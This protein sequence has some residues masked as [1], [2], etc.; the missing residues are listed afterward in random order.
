MD[1]DRAYI[2]SG[3]HHRRPQASQQ[4]ASLGFSESQR[5]WLDPADY[6]GPPLFPCQTWRDPYWN[7]LLTQGEMECFRGHWM[8]WK[9]LVDSGKPCAVVF[10][11]DLKAIDGL[12]DLTVAVRDFTYLG[13]KFLEEPTSEADG[14]LKPGYTYWTIGYSLTREIAQ[15]LLDSVAPDAI[16]PLDEFLPYHYGSNPNVD[17]LKHRQKAP[18][19]IQAFSLPQWIVEPS[20]EEESRTENSPSAFDLQGILFATDKEK[21]SEALSAYQAVEG[22][23]LEV[24][25]EGEPSWDTSGRGGI[26]KLQWLKKHLEGMPPEDKKKRIVLAVDGYDTLPAVFSGRNLTQRFAE[27]GARIV[28]G[29][30]LTCWPDTHLAEAF[31]S[32]AKQ[33]ALPGPYIYPCSGA[34]MGFAEALEAELD[35]ERMGPFDDDQAF[36]HHR[37]LSDEKSVWGVDTEAYLFQSVNKAEQ[38]VG[39]QHGAPFNHKTQCYPA[40]VHANGNSN[41]DLVRPLPRIEVRFDESAGQW[42]EL[43]DGILYVPFLERQT[44]QQIQQ[45]AECVPGLWKPLEGDNVPGDELRIKLLDSRLFRS[46]EEGLEKYVA[47]AIQQRWRPTTWKTVRDMFLI[48]YSTEKQA[49]IRLHEDISYLSC[50][51]VLARACGGGELYFPRQ[52]FTD[53]MIKPGGLLVWPSRITHPHCVTPVAKGRRVSL[54][55]WTEP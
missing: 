43:A 47:P 53:R 55:V 30:E 8:A 12:G 31:Q 54:V 11:D 7:R 38:D 22:F 6:Q 28:V 46:I 36:V 19:R 15:K 44:S 20:G 50:S 14:L 17:R 4:L 49:G 48:R 41:M 5:V 39:R 33:S 9:S 21:A 1:M 3:F 40:I 13:G 35:L 52:G 24:I 23:S 16:I 10:E 37:V 29:G 42:M 34:M 18:A 32:K 51:I 26:Q 25:G 27:M 45:V 2:V